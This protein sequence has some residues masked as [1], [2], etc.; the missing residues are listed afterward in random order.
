MYIF[1]IFISCISFF[2]WAEWI[3]LRNSLLFACFGSSFDV[4][5]FTNG[6]GGGAG[7]GGLGGGPGGGG[8]G[9]ISLY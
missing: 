9:G 6:G 8:G 7:P 3:A 5:S 1:N 2:A 4:P